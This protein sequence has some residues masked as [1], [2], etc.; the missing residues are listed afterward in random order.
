[1]RVLAQ[2]RADIVQ[3]RLERIRRAPRP[4]PRRSLPGQIGAH[5]LPVKPGMAGDRRDRPTTLAQ[6]M[7]FHIVLPCEHEKAVLLRRVLARLA[8]A[9]IEGGPPSSAEPRGG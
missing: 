9:S 1:M 3:E 7:Y 2:P 8:T 6:G 4:H 5:R